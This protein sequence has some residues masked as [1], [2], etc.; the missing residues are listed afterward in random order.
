M[1]CTFKNMVKNGQFSLRYHLKDGHGNSRSP[2]PGTTGVSLPLFDIIFIFSLAALIV[3]SARSAGNIKEQEWHCASVL[4]PPSMMCFMHQIIFS[5]SDLLLPWVIVF[6]GEEFELAFRASDSTGVT[7]TGFVTNITCW[8][9]WN[10]AR[11]HG[12][13]STI[14]TSQTRDT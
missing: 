2:V 3:F 6:D 12:D 4:M 13:W 11:Y 1:L 10:D 9:A 14:D 8:N 5:T 7:L